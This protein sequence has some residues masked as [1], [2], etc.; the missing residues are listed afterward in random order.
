M[1]R[2]PPWETGDPE[3][4]ANCDYYRGDEWADDWDESEDYLD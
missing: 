2:P 1:K 3:D 4:E